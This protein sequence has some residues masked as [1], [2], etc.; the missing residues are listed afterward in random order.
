[1]SADIPSS[2]TKNKLTFEN[3]GTKENRDKWRRRFVPAQKKI[4]LKNFF[5]NSIA[6]L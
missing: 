2:T 6:N 5:Y 3:E 4:E 1:M